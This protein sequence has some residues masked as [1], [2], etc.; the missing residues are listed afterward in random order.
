[1]MCERVKSIPFLLEEG[2]LIFNVAVLTTSFSVRLNLSIF[3]GGL[4]LSSVS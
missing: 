1:M 2:P 3:L 4:I